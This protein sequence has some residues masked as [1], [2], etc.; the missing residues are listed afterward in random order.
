V[1]TVMLYAFGLHMLLSALVSLPFFNKLAL[2]AAL[3]IPLGFLMGM[4]F[5]TGLREIARQDAAFSEVPVETASSSIEW[6]WATNAAAGVLGSV[7]AIVI[8]LHFGLDATLDCAAASY[9][10]AAVLTLLWKRTSREEEAVEE[11]TTE[12]CVEV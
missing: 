7:L 6:A 9:L 1:A 11:S 5:P 12:I 3:L 10:A 2:S 8:A 4:P